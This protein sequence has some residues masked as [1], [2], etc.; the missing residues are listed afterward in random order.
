MRCIYIWEDYPMPELPD[1]AVLARS[2]DQALRG[3]SITDMAVNQP[4]CLNRPE[5]EF[6]EAVISRT[7]QR[8]WQRGKWALADLD[9]DWTLAFNL[10]MGGEV[11]L[12]GPDEIADPRRERVT[13]RL[14]DGQQLWAHFWWFGHVHLVPLGDLSAHPQL[15]RLGPEP[16]ADDLTPQRLAQMLKGKRGAINGDG[17]DRPCRDAVMEVTKMQKVPLGNTGL[18][19]SRLAF[20]AAYLGPLGDRLSS[21]EGAALLLQALDR[22]ISFWDTSDDYGTHP[23]VA[24][25]LRQVPRDQV[26]IASKTVEPVGAVERIR[27]ELDT[28]YLDI[29]FVHCVGSGWAEAAREA[30]RM[31]QQDKAQGRVRA[32][33]FSTHS[34]QVAWL[35]AGWPEVE[36]LLV[37]I[38]A[39][40][41]CTH[42]SRIE[43]GGI[44]EM[45]GAAQRAWEMGK[46]VMA[47]KVMGGGALTAD[48]GAAISFVTRL[49]YVHSLCIGMR[50]L[51]EI[52]DNVR[53]MC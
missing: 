3:R 49:P 47:M 27:A 18:L 5:E 48:P 42:D 13:F 2:M 25:A 24:H 45:L 33:G 31:W 28:D 36:V 4:R 43:D 37:P 41:V 21:G 50:N 52:Q 23:H 22:G 12:H 44:E 14:D 17:N 30:I 32:L 40:G 39:A 38:N 53:L 10:G 46:G 35:A 20:G 26:V 15:S 7:F 34:A 6:R 1:A 19:V 11:R 29:L 16:L 51:K 9:R 8:A